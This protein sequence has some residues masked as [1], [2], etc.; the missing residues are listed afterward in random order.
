[1][2]RVT[3]VGSFNQDLVFETELAPAA[4]ETRLGQFRA[5]PGGKGFNQA[6]AAARMG[7]TVTFVGAVGDDEAGRY[8]QSLA[9]DLDIQCLLQPEV[10]ASTGRAGIIVEADGENRIIVAAGANLELR[11]DFVAAAVQQSSPDVVLVQLEIPLESAAAA[12]AA[13][14]SRGAVG[15]LNPA[16]APEKSQPELLA[17]AA[18][19]TPN[20]TELA[21]LTSHADGSLEDQCAALG[22]PVV[23]A[24][25]G[26]EG[27]ALYRKDSILPFQRHAGY[28]V[29]PRDTTGAGDAFNGALAAEIARHGLPKIESA[30]RCAQAAAALCVTQPGAADAMPDREAVLALMANG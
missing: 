23:V 17:N 10:T 20:E 21:S 22:V 26:A 30:L 16:P 27:S 8:A 19:V 24:T 15:I 29:Q 4:G 25:L 2:N 14:K 18:L 13:A 12:L 5:G 9:S 6:V 1:M 11:P 3:V 7:A 28:S